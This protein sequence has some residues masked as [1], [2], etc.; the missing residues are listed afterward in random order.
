[1][2]HE[3]W[4]GQCNFATLTFMDEKHLIADIPQKAIIEQNGKVLLVRNAESQWQ[5]PGGRLNEGESPSEGIIREIKEELD[6]DVRPDSIFDTV[7]FQSKSGQWHYGVIYICTLLSDVSE[8]KDAA[9]EA[10]QMVWVESMEGTKNLED[11]GS[12]MW[13]EYKNILEKYFNN[14]KDGAIH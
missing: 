1:M 8:M 7:V 14:K 5:L 10:L 6:V 12:V 13:Q 11:D 4:K 9:G 2:E 3:T